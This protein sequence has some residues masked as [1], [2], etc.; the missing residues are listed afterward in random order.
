MKFST[1]LVAGFLSCLACA[2]AQP[3]KAP[4]TVTPP[5]KTSQAEAPSLVGLTRAIQSVSGSRIMQD[6]ARLSSPEF[7]GRQTGTA[8]DRR[9]ALWVAT[10]FHSLKLGPSGTEALGPGDEPWAQTRSI[11]TVQI[12]DEVRLQFL[13]GND[14]IHA[15]PGRDYLPILDSPSANLDAPVVFVG[16]GI[17]D[18]LRG[19]DE[20]EGLDVRNRIVM[21][22][23]GKPEG[24]TNQTSLAD[25]VRVA[26]ARGAL[27]FITL[28]GPVLNAYEARRGTS[29]APLASY[30]LSP[31]EEQLLPGCWISTELA[32]Q[33]FAMDGRAL[34]EVQTRLNTTLKSQSFAG[35]GR[36]RLSWHSIRTDGT[37]F[38]VLGLLAEEARP[39]PNG[40]QRLVIIG[41]HRDHFGRQAGLLFAGADDNASGTAVILEVAR[42]LASSGVSFRRP[43]LFVSFSGEEQNL[44]GSRLYV[45]RPAWPLG[46]TDAMINV[47]HAGIGSGRLTIGVTGPSKE[48]ALVAGNQT[49][50]ADQLD[51]FGFFPGGD[52]VPFKEADVPTYTIVSSGPHPNFHQ[53]SDQADTIRQDILEKVTRYVVALAWNLADRP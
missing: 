26:R 34:R 19:L 20:Y 33:V 25:K 47:D 3:G 32:E 50:I 22:L 53:A 15:R 51:V 52:H 39:D 13:V 2:P 16:Y 24:Y 14:V 7:S 18:P 5:S 10:R 42:V 9:T 6:L 30:T 27:A 48:T 8:D 29:S 40:D 11:P 41:A 49:G 23:R 38:N 43:I 36:V 1:A 45:S 21:F 35:N 46:K 12:G 44:L 31:G 28:Q 4:H 37:L 17:S